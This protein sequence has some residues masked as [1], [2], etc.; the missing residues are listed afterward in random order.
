[1]TEKEFDLTL[2]SAMDA[3]TEAARQAAAVRSFVD[4]ELI[5]VEAAQQEIVRLIHLLIVIS[6]DIAALLDQLGRSASVESG[7]PEHAKEIL[8]ELNVEVKRCME[9]LENNRDIFLNAV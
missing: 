8:A 1:M 4:Q 2:S 3:A 6:S 5:E 7:L 9:M